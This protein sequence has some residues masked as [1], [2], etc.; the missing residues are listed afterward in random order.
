MRQVAL[1]LVVL[2]VASVL[3]LVWRSGNGRFRPRTPAPGPAADDRLTPADVGG[4]LGARAT[5]LQ[6]SSEV[7]AACRRTHDVLAG[8]AADEPGVVHVELDVA[9]HL[10]LVRRLDVMR[11]PTT[12]LLD[13]D[14]AVRG[15]MS[16]AVD[17]RQ[18]LAALASCPGGSCP[19][20]ADVRGVPAA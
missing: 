9:Q 14:G 18:A 6:L 1:V 8:V 2:T 19:D 7:C 17:R 20:G 10:D 15:R 12:L 5:F 3:G 16:G 13:P 11:T 4:A